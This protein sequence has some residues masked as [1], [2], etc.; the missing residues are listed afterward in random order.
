MKI[1][2]LAKQL[3]I[4]EDKVLEAI[5]MFD[6]EYSEDQENIKKNVIKKVEDFINEKGKSEPEEETEKNN[7]SI[8]INKTITVKAFAE[9]LQIPLVD[10]MTTLVKNG[11]MMHLNSV[12]DFEIAAI[13]ADELDKT[14]HEINE[15]DAGNT[16]EIEEI[17]LGVLLHEKDKANLSERAPIVSVVGHVDHGKTSLLDYIRKTNVVSKEAGAI[18]QSIGAY[19][20]K[21]KEKEITFLDTPGH[22]AFVAM[23]KRGVRSTDIAILVIAADDGI[24]PQTIEAIHHIKEAGI[25]LV[26][27]MNKC[28]KEDANPSKLKEQLAAHNILLE[29]WGGNTIGVEVS[30]K[31]GK[32][33]DQLLESVLLVGEMA[34]LKANPNRNAIGT[35]IESN[36]DQKLGASATV[37]IHTGTLYPRD[38][39]IVGE[40]YG[41]VRSLL[42]H[43]KKSIKKAGPAVPVLLTGLNTVPQ[44]GDILKV[45]PNERMAKNLTQNLAQ[46]R[47]KSKRQKESLDLELITRRVKEKRLKGISIILR[48]D[49]EGSIEAIKNSLSKVKTKDAKIRVIRSRTGDVSDSDLSLAQLSNAYL[50]IFNTG[51]STEAQSQAQDNNIEILKYNVIYKLVEELTARMLSSLEKEFEEIA[52]GKAE[53]LKIF[54]TKKDFMICGIDLKSGIVKKRSKARVIR[55]G[56]IVGIIDIPKVQIVAQEVSKMEAPTECG[57]KVEK[58]QIQEKDVLEIFELIER[59]IELIK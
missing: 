35:V 25:P 41:R 8:G 30:A 49:T 20:V 53:I 5:L 22:E 11:F 31:T 59:K 12:I 56:E 32:G 27:A 50:I 14:V 55:N 36:L 29:E 42:N 19:Q 9:I 33:I 58:L 34:E 44:V 48:A 18:T 15:I 47:E 45:V 43:K 7:E 38:I 1:S 37:V 52:L 46:K 21:Y 4:S 24:K 26:V 6:T 10:V 17:D 23:R 28:D 3:N 2:Q 13:I 39:V 54:L 51:I 57:I 16:S 40:A